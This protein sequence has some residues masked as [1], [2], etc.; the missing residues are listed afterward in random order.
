MLTDVYVMESAFLRT[1]KAISKNGAE[2]ERTETND[3]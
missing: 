2:K 1:S 3:N